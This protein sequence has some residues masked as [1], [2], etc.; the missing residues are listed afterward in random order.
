MN[1][2][3]RPALPLR[4]GKVGLKSNPSPP[5][6]SSHQERMGASGFK[7]GTIRLSS[8]DFRLIDLARLQSSKERA[9]V[10]FPPK[11]VLLHVAVCQLS[12]R[13]PV[14]CQSSQ[15]RL[16][17][18]SSLAQL[19]LAYLA[20]C[21]CHPWRRSSRRCSPHTTAVPLSHASLTLWRSARLF[22]NTHGLP[23]VGST[24]A[25]LM[26]TLEAQLPHLRQVETSL[27][28]SL[29]ISALALGEHLSCPCSRFV[30]SAL[31]VS[32]AQ[33]VPGDGC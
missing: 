28:P 25:G 32:T 1:E 22:A 2:G 18:R 17:F 4:V 14:G 26:S 3:A 27:R 15:H 24:L 19:A 33:A 16:P 6:R 21:R 23:S 9:Q 12:S 20:Q 11:F 29:W 7:T 31:A 13:Q 30:I 8:S 10:V 5:E